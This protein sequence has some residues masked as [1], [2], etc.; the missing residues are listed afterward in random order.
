[1]KKTAL[2]VMVMIAATAASAQAADTGFYVGGGLGI[3][4][5]DMRD[6]N[7]DYADLRFEQQDFG[8]KLFGGFRPLKYFAVE[9]GYTDFGNVSVYEGGNLEFYREANVDVTMWTGY[10]VGLL[11][12][13]DKVDLFAK[14][15]YASWNVDN[16]VQD[17]EGSED[18]SN[19]GS[20]LAW[21]LGINFRFKKFGARVEGDWLDLPDTGGAFLFSASLMYNF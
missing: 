7:P 18:R 21:G 17:N 14:L 19:S 12:V 6:F 13:G 8:W 16:V 11:P 20:D 4:S 9:A 10:A 5:L 1:M 15:G 2:L 3:S